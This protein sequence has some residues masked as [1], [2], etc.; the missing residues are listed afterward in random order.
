MTKTLINLD[1]DDKAWLDREAK[2]QHLPMTE[3]VRQAVR[4][5]RL[6]EQTGRKP[7]LAIV[8][9]RTSGLWKHG[10][11]LDWQDRLRDEWQ[12]EA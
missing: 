3:L 10:D 5:Y 12:R 11:G 1:A 8:L 6:R 7:S 9:Q 2:R 4:S